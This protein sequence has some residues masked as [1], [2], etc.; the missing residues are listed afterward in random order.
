M[1]KTTIQFQATSVVHAYD[2]YFNDHEHEIIHAIRHLNKV[3]NG[4][5]KSIFNAEPSVN[6]LK[7][8]YA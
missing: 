2:D 3:H 8:I 7:S 1:T 5:L 6:K 4:H